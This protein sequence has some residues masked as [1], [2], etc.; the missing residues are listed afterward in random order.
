MSFVQLAPET[1][2]IADSGQ[3]EKAVLELPRQ[4]GSAAQIFRRLSRGVQHTLNLF[5]D[6]RATSQ[7]HAQQLCVFLKRHLERARGRCVVGRAQWIE[8]STYQSSARRWS[9]VNGGEP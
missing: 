3:R 1:P 2:S 5:A 8:R 9:I 6:S 7:E 4:H